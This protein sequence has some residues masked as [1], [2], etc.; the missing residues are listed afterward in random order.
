MNMI[1]KYISLCKKAYPL[2]EKRQLKEVS[3]L[4]NEMREIEKSYG[5]ENLVADF[6]SIGYTIDIKGVVNGLLQAKKE[7]KSYGLKFGKQE[8]GAILLE[9]FADAYE[10]RRSK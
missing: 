9:K 4:L 8:I 10:Q 6:D 7:Y 1:E 5:I 3:P 2:I